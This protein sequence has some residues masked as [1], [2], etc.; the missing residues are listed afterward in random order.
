MA[1][2][3][4]SKIRVRQGNLADLPVLDPGELGYAKDSRRLFIGNDTVNVGTGNGVFVGFTLP[5]SMSKPIIS[6]VFVDGVA[7]NTANYTIREVNSDVF[8]DVTLRIYPFFNHRTLLL[9][10]LMQY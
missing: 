1:D 4:I 7:Q 3:R 6:T 8:H 5:L 9:T 2:T 10:L